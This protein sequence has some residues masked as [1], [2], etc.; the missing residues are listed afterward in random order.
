MKK[1]LAL[2]ICLSLCFGIQMN[3]RVAGYYGS[4]NPENLIDKNS[5]I[6]RKLYWSDE[7][8]GDSLN[9]NNWNI[10]VG[11]IEPQWGSRKYSTARMENVNVQNGLLDITSQISFSNEGPVVIDSGY[12]GSINTKN[13][14][15]FK[16]GEI[17]IRAKMAPGKGVSSLSYFLGKEK[18]WPTCG[19]VD[20]FEYSNHSDLLTQAIH[21]RKYNELNSSS[22][23]IWAQMIDKSKFHIFK[24]RWYDK[25]IELYIDNKLSATYDP[26]NYSTNTNPT[27]DIA[28]WPF[29]QPMMLMFRGSLDPHL[30]GERDPE[31]WT[32][33][34]E[35]EDSKDYETHTYVDYVKAYEIRVD[36]TIANQLKSKP[37]LYMAYKNKKSKKLTIE[38]FPGDWVN[39]YEFRIYKNK[40]NAKKNK[41]TLVKKIFKGSPTTVKLKNKKLKN[42][43][44][45]YVRVR[46]YKYC[47]DV[48]YYSKW[49]KSLKVK[50]K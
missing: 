29:N 25:R 43:K 30:G 24:M 12:T 44:T 20:L 18:I 23:I 27:E 16:Y 41:K 10:D 9:T 17:E 48:K 47:Y 38:L 19:E 3:T 31:G 40:K 50:I 39:G 11:D 15:Y 35:N 1:V 34:K 14:V 4:G 8:N 28:V 6:V 33:V 7:F 26:A 5:G 22:P 2:I 46:S 49:S 42:K 21:T 13:K 45:L 37:T 32:F 36:Q